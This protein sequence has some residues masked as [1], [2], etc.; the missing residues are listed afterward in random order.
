MNVVIVPFLLILAL[1]MIAHTKIRKYISVMSA[2]KN[3][4]S[5]M[6]LR[7]KNFALIVSRKD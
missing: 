7:A 1:G 2:K 4:M 6:N 3:P 5:F